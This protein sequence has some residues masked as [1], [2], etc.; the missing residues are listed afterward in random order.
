[1]KKLTEKIDVA[2]A[3]NAAEQ[4]LGTVSEGSQSDFCKA[5]EDAKRIVR[6]GFCDDDEIA[7][8]P[9]YIDSEHELAR[10]LPKVTAILKERKK[11]VISLLTKNKAALKSVADELVQLGTLFQE[12]VVAILRRKTNLIDGKKGRRGNE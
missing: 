3:G 6:G 7:I 4:I 11:I 9:S 12:D 8:T 2:L 10:I 1:M 5:T